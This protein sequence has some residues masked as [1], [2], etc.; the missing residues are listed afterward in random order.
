MTGN[1]D[2]WVLDWYMKAFPLTDEVDPKGPDSDD[3]KKYFLKNKVTRGGGVIGGESQ[4]QLFIR[5]S[6]GPDVTGAGVGIRCVANHSAV[7]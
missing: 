7:L 3:V 1:V 5:L 6:I 2:E 4:M